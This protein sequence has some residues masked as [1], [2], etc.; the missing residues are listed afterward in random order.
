MKFPQGYNSKYLPE[1]VTRGSHVLKLLRNIYSNKA[2]G[3]VWN[4]YLDKGLQEAGFEPS[5]VDP[6]LYYKEGVILLVY[7][8]GCILM[9]TTDAAIDEA[10]HALR[11]S[12]QNFTIE[13]EGAVGNFLG[14]KIDC[15]DDGTNMLTQPQLIDLIIEDLNMKDNT[16]PRAFPACSSK[17]LHKDTD[18][19]SIKANFHYC[20]VIAKLNF[21]EK[22]TCPDIPVSVHQCARFQDNLKKSHLQ[23]MRTIGHYLIGTR[24]KGIMMR[25]DHTKSFECWMDADFAGSWYEPR[26]AKDPMT[27]KSRSRWVIMYARCPITWS[28]KIQTL[29]VLS[30][31]EAEYIALSSALR[32]QIPIMQL[33]KEVINQGIDANFAPPRVHCTVFEDNGVAIKLVQLPKIRPRMKHTN[34]YYHHFHSYTEGN[35]PEITIWAGPV[36]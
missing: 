24:D 1:G 28:S 9:G 31:M 2:A 5:K 8:D 11:A 29:T 36:R 7:V 27:A 3:R 13:D 20:S 16:K 35:D 17:L 26:A 25:P 15:S 6:C 22:S 18:G 21:L 10:I 23:A 30:T 12:K 33:M 19:E 32:D 4:K 34:N 14:V